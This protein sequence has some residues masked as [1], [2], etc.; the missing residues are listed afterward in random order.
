MVNGNNYTY[1]M[2][3]ME[4]AILECGCKTFRQ[5]CKMKQMLIT[6]VKFVI[7]T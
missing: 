3:V 2:V 1:V 4:T 7:T 6:G 5:Q